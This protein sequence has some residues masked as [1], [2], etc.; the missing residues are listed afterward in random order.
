MEAVDSDS[1]STSS[2]RSCSSATEEA[3]DHI[4]FE[5]V[6]RRVE[7]GED[8][9]PLASVP[10]KKSGPSKGSSRSRKS[11]RPTGMGQ[12]EESRVSSNQPVGFAVDRLK[13]SASTRM[14]WWR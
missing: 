12:G 4:L 9:Q 3:R 5:T 10:Y 13:L 14:S 11:S 1:S 8:I 7:T 6:L 2:S